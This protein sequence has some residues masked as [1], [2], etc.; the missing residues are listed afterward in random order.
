LLVVLSCGCGRLGYE[1]RSPDD[2]AQRPTTT[3][4]PPGG[5][6]RALPTVMLQ[7]DRPATIYYTT[8]GSDPTSSS[9]SGTSP[10]T[11]GGLQPG[12]ELRFFAMDAAGNTEEIKAEIY[13]LNRLGAKPVVGFRAEESA[14]DIV[15][16]WQLPEAP[17]LIEVI[18]ARVVDVAATQPSDGAELSVGDEIGSAEIIY[19][20]SET[21]VQLP[22]PRPGQY[23][24]VAWGRYANGAFSDGRTAE[25]RI[26]APA[27]TGQLI[28]DVGAGTVTVTRQ[29]AHYA[30]AGGQVAH[31]GD[32]TVTFWL[33]IT[34][35]LAGLTLNSKVAIRALSTGSFGNPDGAIAGGPLSALP[36]RYFGPR[37]LAEGEGT[38]RSIALTQISADDIITVDFEIQSDPGLFWVEWDN[39]PRG[40]LLD[41]GGGRSHD[42]L[43]IAPTFRGLGG[44]RGLQRSP[45]GRYLYAGARNAPRVVKIDTTTLTVVGGIDIAIDKASG[46]LVDLRIDPSG[47]RL[48]G[49]LNSGMHNSAHSSTVESF[50]ART[51]RGRPVQ[52]NAVVLIEIDARTMS[53]TGRVVLDEGDAVFRGRRMALSH[54]GDLA[55]VAAGAQYTETSISRVYVVDLVNMAVVDGDPTTPEIEPVSVGDMRPSAV[56][57]S[58][59]DRY[60]VFNTSWHEECTRVGV[61]DL[62]RDLAVASYAQGAVSSCETKAIGFVPRAD[63]MIWLVG[64][65][66]GIV[67]FS[68]SL[69]TFAPVGNH[70]DYARSGALAAGGSRLLLL[71]FDSLLRFDAANGTLLDEWPLGGSQLDHTLVLAP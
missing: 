47:R 36:Y 50:E 26:A 37:S 67:L 30:V 68:P 69:G 62:Q 55:A 25:I 38:T 2:A 57:F 51:S 42:A 35:G 5:V 9:A 32:R 12:T 56:A 15:L 6:Y 11:V 14:G 3:A 63:G 7:A 20:G 46:A 16:R 10:V 4:S 34:S 13:L 60:V 66:T 45:D 29:P 28:V 40:H 21:S 33:T 24:F 70:W 23:T 31:D 64:A 61:I 49:V 65:Y 22:S 59:D 1:G 8:D 54:G 44:Y 17:D 53:E 48:F 58:A 19:A 43:P 41:L 27:Q 71:T 18:I 52:D 39:G